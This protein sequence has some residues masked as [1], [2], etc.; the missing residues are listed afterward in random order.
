MTTT[1]V[2]QYKESCDISIMRP[3]PWENPFVIGLDGTREEVIDKFKHRLSSSMDMKAIWMRA[4]IHK[5][6]GKR[7]GCCCKPQICHG[8]ILAGAADAV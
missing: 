3:G 4:N 5:L 6:K 8:D 2:N 7:L 1:V